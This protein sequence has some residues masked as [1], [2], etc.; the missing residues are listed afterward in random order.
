MTD[1]RHAARDN[2]RSLTFTSSVR[3][4]KSDRAIAKGKSLFLSPTGRRSSFILHPSSFG[5]S[6]VVTEEH[7]EWRVT[8]CFRFAVFR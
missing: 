3:N 7:G 8:H 2:I 4:G 5:M 1:D 6:S